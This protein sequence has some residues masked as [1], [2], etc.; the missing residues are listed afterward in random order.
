MFPNDVGADG[1]AKQRADGG[2]GTG[3]CDGRQASI[4]K[5]AQAWAKAKTQQGAEREDMVGGTTRV[6]IMLGDFKP[7]SMIGQAVEHVWG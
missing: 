1:F 7:R 2:I 4:R 6:G 3:R 5:V